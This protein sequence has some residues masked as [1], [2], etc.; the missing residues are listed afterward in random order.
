MTWAVYLNETDVTT[1]GVYPESAPDWLSAPS[2]DYPMVAIPGRQGAVFA[3]DPTTPARTLRLSLMIQPPALT[4]AARVTAEDNLKALAYR[5]LVKVI[6]DDGTNAPRQID[7]VCTSCSIVPR[8]HPT[9][10]LV[11]D[12]TLS[13][14]CPDPTWYDVVGQ[15]VGFSTTATAVP[16]GTAPSGGIVR[17]TAPSWSADVDAPV[18]H[19]L[20]AG[21]VTVQSMTFGGVT[22]GSDLQ[23][24]LDYLEIDLD[25]ATIT[26][27]DSGVASSGI[28]LL[29]AGDFFALDP[30]DGDPLNSSYPMLKVT[31]SGGTPTAQWIG[32]RRWL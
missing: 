28:T 29:T 30:Q 13:L 11:S 19:Y 3:A 8:R 18:L 27:Y 14:L 32:A 15:M 16:L 6:V 2:R 20:N 25:R 10:S 17:I 9:V 22:G 7:A 26:R 31:A 21:G 1:L 12:A 23:A 4:L 5:A 24:G